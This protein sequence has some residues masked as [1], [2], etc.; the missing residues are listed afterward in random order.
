M[1]LLVQGVHKRF[2]PVQALAGV[3]LELRAG[4]VLG[5][6]GPNGAGKTTLVKVILGLLLPEE[7]EV[8][9][10]EEGR[11]RRP[12]GHEFGVLLEG[13]RNLY[14]NLPLLANALY[15]GGIRGLSPKEVRPRFLHWL[16]RFGLKERL[17]APLASLS[18][19]MQQKAALAL[20]LALRPRFLLL[21]EPTLGLDPVSRGELEAILLSLKGEGIGILLTSHDL[22]TVERVSDRVAFLQGGRLLREGP[23][24]ALLREWAGEGYL[25]RLAEPVAEALAEALGPGWLAEGKDRL[26]FLGEWAA[27][28]EALPRVPVE[29]LEV[30]RGE[31]SLETVFLRLFGREA[32]KEPSP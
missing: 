13:S 29:V 28:K 12:Q 21:D 19:G 25:L 3:S 27:L 11:R 32:P 30:S 10:E 23:T 14:L 24:R 2:G 4:E 6:L 15:F 9:L 31:P 5:L 26:V 1:R 20:A 8:Y 7:G 17:H 22:A 16:E 18:R